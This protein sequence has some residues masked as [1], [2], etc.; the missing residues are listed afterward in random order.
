MEERAFARAALIRAGACAP[1]RISVTLAGGRRFV[2][3]PRIRFPHNL[4]RNLAV[5]GCADPYVLMLDAD[6][7]VFPPL[8]AEL[9]NRTVSRQLAGE[10]GARL[11]IVVPSFS[12]RA[13]LL[14][15]WDQRDVRRAP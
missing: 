11:A 2:S 5:G 14:A 7:E 1:E 13:D 10:A 6:L 12:V 4:L 15:S 3:P 8:S 9:L